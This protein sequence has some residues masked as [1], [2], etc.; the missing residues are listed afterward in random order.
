V[1]EQSELSSIELQQSEAAGTGK[2]RE[3]SSI[4]FPYTDLDEA[5][6]VAKALHENGDNAQLTQLAA[7]L[8]HASVEGGAFRLRVSGARTFGLVITSGK[9]I[10]LTPLGKEMVDPTRER[11]ARAKAFLTVQ[12][13]RELYGRFEGSLLPPPNGLE[14]VIRDM[15]VSRKQT[16]KARQGFQRS[17]EQANFFEYGSDRLVYPK[18]ITAK[19]LD[20]A[21][22]RDRREEGRKSQ[23]KPSVRAGGE[24][25]APVT[26]KKV[27][28][29]S[30]DGTIT[31][32]Y[33][34]NLFDLNRDDRE[35][36][37]GLID[38]LT[39]YDEGTPGEAR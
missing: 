6:Q 20:G 28:L 5:V 13:Y 27:E 1:E 26:S 17:A 19:E 16:D 11:L 22:A 10:E 34:A 4:Q 18:G 24:A 2:A 29:R 35:F 36:L 21:S 31:L 8:N 30:G 38:K 9:R 3:F 15:G 14:Q 39:A 32:S 23:D 37:L 7:A 25:L 33:S 12:L